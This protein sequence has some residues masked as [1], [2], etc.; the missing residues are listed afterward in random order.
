VQML[1]L[2]DGLVLAERSGVDRDRRSGSCSAA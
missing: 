1:A 2:A